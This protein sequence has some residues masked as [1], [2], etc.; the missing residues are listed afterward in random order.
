MGTRTGPSAL[1]LEGHL[2]AAAATS[3][4]PS[5]EDPGRVLEKLLQYG[6][7][8][9]R[10][11]AVDRAVVDGEG[12]AH[13]LARHHRVE[14]DDR[15]GTDGADRKDRG[16]WRVYDRGELLHAVHPEVGDRDRTALELVLLELAGASPFGQVTQRRRDRRHW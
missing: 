12:Q 9:C 10:K 8:A 1:R 4:S 15:L 2:L 5:G 11:H 6:E 14:L 7:P 13:Q 16:V 3:R